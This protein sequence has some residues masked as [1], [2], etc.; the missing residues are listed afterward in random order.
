MDEAGDPRVPG[1][2]Q[3]AASS[4]A[5]MRNDLEAKSDALLVLCA[6]EGFSE[7]EAAAA[8]EILA[9]DGERCDRIVAGVLEK[10]AAGR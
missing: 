6:L 2:L 10:I 1:T 4:N 8:L 7:A 9:F 5:R 3:T